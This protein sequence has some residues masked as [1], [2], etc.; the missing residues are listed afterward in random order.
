MLKHD[1][2]KSR[3][4]Y[5]LKDLLIYD[6][7]IQQRFTVGCNLCKES[8]KLLQFYATCQ[9]S[10]LEVGVRIKYKKCNKKVYQTLYIALVATLRL[11]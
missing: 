5:N 7:H 1:E 4:S 6:T 11:T 2:F 9:Q 8:I 10:K 3:E